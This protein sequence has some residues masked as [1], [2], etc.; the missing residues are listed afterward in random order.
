MVVG[1][2]GLENFFRTLIDVNVGS[3]NKKVNDPRGIRA[4]SQTE[5]RADHE[6][7]RER[8]GL[9]G[10]GA[11]DQGDGPPGVVAVEVVGVESESGAVGEDR[12]GAGPSDGSSSRAGDDEVLHGLVGGEGHCGSDADGCDREKGGPA[13]LQGDDLVFSVCSGEFRDTVRTR[14]GW[15]ETVFDKD[16]VFRKKNSNSFVS[17]H[18][19]LTK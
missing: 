11:V 17:T 12:S 3:L 5:S 9:V 18:E 14:H 10:G 13:G 4:E 6:I 2:N 19:I 7:G 16:K 1:F 8:E 15:K